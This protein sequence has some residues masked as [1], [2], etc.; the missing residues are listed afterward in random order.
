MF[1]SKNTYAHVSTCF[2]KQ[3]QNNNKKHLELFF[4]FLV[5]GE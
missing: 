5:T 4:T 1:K 3:K 2:E